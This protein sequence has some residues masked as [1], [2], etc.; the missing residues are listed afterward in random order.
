MLREF[1]LPDV[2]E[3]L[4]EAEIVKWHVAIGDSVKVNQTIVE[5]ET[6][7]AVVELPCPFEGTV[8]SLMAAEGQTVDVGSPIIAVKTGEDEDVPVTGGLAE[9]LVPPPPS[10]QAPEQ[11]KRQPV[12]VG[13]G[14]KASSTKRRP[15][16]DSADA[17]APVSPAAPAVAPTAAPAAV[18]NGGPSAVPAGA[19]GTAAA[20]VTRAPATRT[21]GV[22][23]KPPVRKLAKDLGVDLAAL[24]GTGPQG[25]ITRA[26]VEAAVGA[27]A[28]PAAAPSRAAGAV[29]EER[30]P[31]RGVR[32][33][34][35]QAMVASAFTAPH[36][37]EFLQ[38][39]VTE[40]MEAVRRLRQLPEFAEVRVSPLLLVA[41]ALLTAVRRHPMANATWTDEEIVVKHYVNLGVAAATER[42]LI[43]PNVK[44]A[45][46]MSLPELARALAELT[47]RARA[48]RCQPA[49]LTGGTITI[50]NVGV[51]GVDAGTPILN[52]GEVA[53]LAFGQIRDMP[54]VV[55]GQIAVRKVTTLALSFDHRVIDGELGSR[56]LRDVGSMLEDP[57]RMLAW[58]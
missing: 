3:G 31:V 32:K 29:R 37:T 12:L 34:T 18:A 53:I 41:K 48:G 35:A 51:F 58:S 9:D 14:V 54:W 33:A 17:P 50:T 23:A 6:A 2:G 38:I 46:A 16:K 43:V 21:I 47:E 30:I 52:P 42:G 11:E 49:E 27:A 40:T 57:L 13:Y 24:T 7:K 55:D 15:R 20:S 44:D 36:V 10:G 22:L 26:D 45:D 28:V 5:I 19:P 25:S 1:R 56:V 4:T 8:S 39:D